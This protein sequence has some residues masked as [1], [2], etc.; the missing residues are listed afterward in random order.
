MFHCHA[1]G[2]DAAKEELVSEVFT[3]EGRFVQV[4]DIPA[5]VCDRCGEATFSRETTEKIRQLVHSS[6][7]PVKTVP[8]DVF[9]FAL[10]SSIP[11]LVREKPGKKY[12]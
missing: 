10:S 11:S 6:K 8:M 4:V 12:G 7:Q 2:G 3:I 1:C 9:P 5:R